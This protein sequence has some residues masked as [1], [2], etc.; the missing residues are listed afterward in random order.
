LRERA[1]IA[2]AAATEHL[3]K[4]ASEKLF[5]FL[6]LLIKLLLLKALGVSSI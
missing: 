4:Q 1:R 2:A 3:C 5:L 6:F